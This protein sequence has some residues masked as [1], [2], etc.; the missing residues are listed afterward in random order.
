M[1]AILLWWLAIQLFALAALPLAAR[2]FAR[3]P[4]RGYPFAKALGLLLVSF[5]LWLG[6]SSHLIPNNAGGIVAA[7]IIVAGVSWWLGRDGLR[8]DADGRRP[9]LTWLRINRGLVLA[10]ELL[11]LAVLVGWAV[12]RAYNPDIAGTEKPMEFAF[13]NGVLRSRLFPPQDPWLSGYGISYYYFGYVM[14]DVFILLT[15]VDPAVGFNLGVALWYA[16][17]MVGAFGVVYDLVRL[18]ETGSRK[19]E[20]GSWKLEAGSR[21]PEAGS[22][23]LEADA[24]ERAARTTHN[25]TRNTQSEGRGI[26]YGLLGA[27]FV[28]FLGNLEGLVELAYNKSLVPLSWIQWLNIKQLTDNP[29]TGGLTGGF[30]WWWH[31][32]RVIHD[33]LPGP[34]GKPIDFEVIDEFPSFSF[35]LGDMHPHVLGLPFAI[36]AVALALN[37]LLGARDRVSGIRDWVLGIAPV[38]E[39]SPSDFELRASNRQY[40]IPNPQYLIPDFWRSLGHATGLGTP[41]ILLYAIV[42]GGLSFLNTWDFPIY[43][44]LAMLALGTGLALADRLSWAVVGRAAA[45]GVVLA[46][47]GWLLYLPFYIG[48]QSQ[49][50]GILPNLLFPS[51]FSQFFVMF[52]TFLV[53]AVCFLVLLTREASGRRTLRG[54][55]ATLPWTLL[56]PLLIL[57]VVA[58]GLVILP[59]G[60]AFVQDVLNNPAVQANIT[61][62]TFSG[63][64][65]LIV[66]LRVA[67]PWTYL[68]L[69]LLIAWAV[70]VLWAA[71]SGY[72]DTETRG[73]GD[74][75]TERHGDTETRRPGDTETRGGGGYPRVS[76]S[77]HLPISPD[78]FAVLM[79]ILA[80]VLTLVPEFVYLRDLFG[81][82]MNTV[83]KFYYQAWLLLGLASV[84]GLSRLAERMTVVWL[85]APALV[86]AGV[87]VLGGLWYPLAAI[88]SR[89]DNFRG[90]PTLDGLAYLRRSDPADVAAIEWLR[91][92]VAPDAVVLEAPGGSYSSDGAERISMSTGNPTLL[93]WDFHE[94][95][96]RGNA[97]YDK[98]AAGRPDAINQIYRT[99]RSED[100]QGLLDQWGIQYVLIGALE[101]SK[102]G[103]GDAS[104]AR[105]DRAL[106]LVYDKDG[107]RIY[108]R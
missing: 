39:R 52:G 48:F 19:P 106:K 40:P 87:F 56:L 93:G 55:L 47:L 70:G 7:L 44:G 12:F 31:A 41:G 92:N 61:D 63:L 60:K 91:A 74:T 34:D 94:R 100:L 67:T 103:I 25:A 49:L 64:M 59:Q 4:G 8:R 17:I 72:G 69:A 11:F 71:L 42:L 99:A 22:R 75:E 98:L 45:G 101:R 84:Y 102:Y 81:T 37:L 86:L 43:V 32:S 95:Q 62:R 76:P 28:G 54:F 105:F 53:V 27:L 104:L 16:L 57:A 36:L 13:I 24:D 66:R 2:L 29:P 73:H 89:A 80:L 9:L 18:A 23:K 10:T 107:V 77:P 97:G 5:V 88:P 38:P 26:R 35:I 50:G 15:G 78:L 68:V 3:L 82:R 79:I 83:F 85:K 46:A 20:A 90:Q 58:L 21:K 108:A 51:R 1:I 6:A 33:W 96:W 14:L 30:W 65:E